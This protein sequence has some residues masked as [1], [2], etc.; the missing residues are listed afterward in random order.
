MAE[1]PARKSAAPKQSRRSAAKAT[2]VDAVDDAEETRY[3][4]DL[5]VVKDEPLLSP[6]GKV[7]GKQVTF[8]SYRVWTLEDGTKTHAC[9]KCYEFTGSRGDVRKHLIAEHGMSGGG[10]RKSDPTATAVSDFMRMPMAE[11]IELVRSAGQWGEMLDTAETQLAEYKQRALAAEAEN[12]KF[13]A[14]FAR[15]GLVSKEETD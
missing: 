11:V 2:A 7:N 13:R 8:S 15:L 1:A 4:D 3:V 12:R 9:A 5:R 10:A 14:A 6:L